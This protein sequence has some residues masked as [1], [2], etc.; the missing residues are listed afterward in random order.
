MYFV[1]ILKCS[2]G[3]YYIGIAQ[4]VEKRL[5]A[6]NGMTK[7]G[8]KYTSGRRPVEL[9]YKEKFDSKGEALKREYQLKQLSHG[10]KRQVVDSSA[11]IL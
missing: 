2:D 11:N 5:K 7:G 10:E 4:N 9:L 1:Y 8:A 3:T 6:H